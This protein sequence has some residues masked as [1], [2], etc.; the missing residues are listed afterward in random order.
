[1]RRRKQLNTESM[2]Y[3][4]SRRLCGIAMRLSGVFAFMEIMLMHGF[5]VTEQ[6]LRRVVLPRYPCML[7]PHRPVKSGIL[8]PC[9]SK[10]AGYASGEITSQLSAWYASS[11]LAP[12]VP[13]PS[14]PVGSASANAPD[15]RSCDPRTS[16]LPR[17]TQH[18]LLSE[19]FV[20][21]D[22]T[23]L[24]RWKPFPFVTGMLPSKLL[25]SS[26][27]SAAASAI[28]DSQFLK[29]HASWVSQHVPLV[30][31]ADPLL[32][33]AAW[34][35]A[36]YICASYVALL[37]GPVLHTAL[38]S[39]DAPASGEPRR[40]SSSEALLDWIR[41]SSSAQSHRDLQQRELVQSHDPGIARGQDT[42]LGKR[43]RASCG[44]EGGLA[45][46]ATAASRLSL[47]DKDI[48]STAETAREVPWVF[49]EPWQFWDDLSLPVRER[50]AQ[51]VLLYQQSCF[52][53]LEEDGEEPRHWIE[54][55]QVMPS[56]SMTLST[57][58]CT[59]DDPSASAIVVLFFN[60]ITSS[61]HIL[62]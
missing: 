34:S 1:M 15:G 42:L 43:P 45:P 7:Y 19:F 36:R 53:N 25:R 14:A 59:A 9:V 57:C 10:D 56:I 18:A 60:A 12:K 24:A 39:E 61:V 48:A 16:P 11:S 46:S 22:D 20:K 37:D 23:L 38:F 31:V 50:L 49:R 4:L 26:P 33:E 62:L 51:A 40:F 55:S 13:L 52:M 28:T 3:F 44:H 5:A 58:I 29:A 47:L 30:V 54:L 17:F 35:T 8:Q 27:A 32:V 6:L 41:L 21:P 2:S